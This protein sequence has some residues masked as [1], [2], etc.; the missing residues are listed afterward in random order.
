MTPF[1]PLSA[2]RHPLETTPDAMGWLRD[3]SAVI[4]DGDALR[5]RMAE[6]GYLFLPGALDR[7]LALAA[8]RICLEKLAAV[9]A[10]EPGTDP[11]AAIARTDR[12]SYF[13]ARLAHDNAPLMA[14]LYDGKMMALF[15]RLF[16]EPAT[17]FDFTWMRAVSPGNATAP[18]CDLV[19]M[20]RGT[21]DLYTAWTPLGDIP[22]QIGG[23]IVLENSHKRTDITGPYLQQDV[24]SYCEN[25]PNAEAVRT[26]KMHWEDWRGGTDAWDGA[27][28]HDPPA[29]RKALGGRWLVAN[30]RLGDVLIFSMATIHASLDNGS[31]T[32]RLSSDSRYQRAREPRDA[33]WIVG[34]NG[35]PPPAHGL[36][37]KRGRIC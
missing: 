1:P 25:G 8:R 31:A 16:D 19:Y 37:A 35:E 10:F 6:D 24:D 7:D 5:L 15:D 26:G 32:L 2:Y 11:Q 4:D 9:G 30:Y 29:L 27:L 17:H 14:L 21:R 22:L 36:A 3:S 13:D 23:L 28:S 20:G 34:P 18:H 12:A 33:R